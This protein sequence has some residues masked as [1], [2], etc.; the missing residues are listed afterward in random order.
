M[1]QLTFMLKLQI[2]VRRFVV[3]LKVKSALLTGT[4]LMLILPGLAAN[5]LTSIKS[6]LCSIPGQFWPWKTVA[7]KTP[8]KNTGK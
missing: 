6:S 3:S 4:P 5:P 7:L 1:N 2:K 8:Y